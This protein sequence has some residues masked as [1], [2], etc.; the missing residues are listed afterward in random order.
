M[1][2]YFALGFVSITFMASNAFGLRVNVKRGVVDGGPDLRLGKNVTSSEQM[3][4]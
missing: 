1:E 3:A 2:V 4:R